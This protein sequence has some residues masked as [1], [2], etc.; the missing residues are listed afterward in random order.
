MT[1]FQTAYLSR[2]LILQIVLTWLCFFASQDT[3]ACARQGEFVR[4]IVFGADASAFSKNVRNFSAWRYKDRQWRQIPIQIDERN[5]KNEYVLDSGMPFTKDTDDG[6]LDSND[7]IVVKGSDLGDDFTPKDIPADLVGQAQRTWKL[8]FCSGEEKFGFLLLAVRQY[9]SNKASSSVAVKFARDKIVTQ[10]YAYQFRKTHPVLLGALDILYGGTAVKLFA[11]SRFNVAFR[12]PF[13]LPDFT[14]T[15]ESFSSEIESWQEGPIRTI[16]AVGVKLKKFLSMFDFHMFSELVFY[17]N[18]FQIPTSLE[19]PFDPDEWLKPGSGLAYF[20]KLAEPEKWAIS[21]NV[22]TLPLV[23]APAPKGVAKEYWA[24]AE[25]KYGAIAMKI[26]I[27][28]ENN[29]FFPHPYFFRSNMA[30]AKPWH[31]EWPWLRDMVG[32]FGVF[33]D[34]SSVQRGA[35][36]FSLDLILDSKADLSV[37]KVFTFPKVSWEMLN[38]N[39]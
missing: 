9:R 32:D 25:G 6:M 13:W 22:E 23:P 27:S 35:Y 24:L 21:S 5:E 26:D 20:V 19:F 36:N 29:E 37:D 39:Q 30:K 3:L 15:E 33:V 10:R 31:K 12:L 2:Y 8:R 28:S 7:E 34:I 14:L 17:E 38:P 4:P 18:S 16:V 1:I 11:S